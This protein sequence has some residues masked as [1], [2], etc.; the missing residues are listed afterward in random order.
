MALAKE[1]MESIYQF[2]YR[3]IS[4]LDFIW[5]E[6]LMKFV[7]SSEKNEAIIEHE[8]TVFKKYSKICKNYE[9]AFKELDCILKLEQIWST[10]RKK[11]KLEK[12][13]ISFYEESFSKT[14]IP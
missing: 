2:Y 7:Y 11:I 12:W 13:A 14:K 5:E 4:T 10:S 9:S 6:I 8:D 1:Y 3:K